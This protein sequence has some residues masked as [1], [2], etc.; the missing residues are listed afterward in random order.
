V[1][2]VATTL[3]KHLIQ[4]LTRLVLHESAYCFLRIDRQFL[5]A[6]VCRFAVA[7]SSS[8]MLDEDLI[9]NSF[10]GP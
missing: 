5:A 7:V 10:E 1:K 3:H 6:D 4:L 2:A 8:A 9:F